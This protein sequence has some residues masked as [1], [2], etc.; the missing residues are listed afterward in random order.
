MLL[1]LIMMIFGTEEKI[2]MKKID[3]KYRKTKMIFSSVP[4]IIEAK[5]GI[6]KWEKL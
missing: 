3:K 4:K 2:I 1:N 6:L 5:G